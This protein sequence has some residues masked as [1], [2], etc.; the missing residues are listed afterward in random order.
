MPV[1]SP[2]VPIVL[3]CLLVAGAALA[4][5]ER[6]S[7]GLRPLLA[8][9]AWLLPSVA[10]LVAMAIWLGT[11]L[12]EDEDDWLPVI[13]LCAAAVVQGA[14]AL[15]RRPVLDA[16]DAA[17][18]RNGRA[19]LVKGEAVRAVIAVAVILGS[20]ALGWIAL[21]LPW[22]QQ[23]LSIDPLYS[24]LELSLILGFLVL[25][26]FVFQRRGVGV[27]VGVGA[28]WFVGIA[29]F[30]VTT[31]KSASIMPG[32][33]LA[34]ETAAAVGGGYVYA[35]DGP[36][37]I[38]IAC[39]LAAIGACSFVAPSRPRGGE[40]LF[41]NVVG[42]VV[43]ALV[44]ASL[45]WPGVT[46]D[47]EE[48]LDMEVDYWASVSYFRAHG[49]IPSFVK[50]VQD[51]PIDR[52]E[53]Y[54]DE[55]AAELEARYAAEYDAGAGS[56]A[57]RLAAEEQ[58]EQTRP[59]VICIM[60][61]SFSDLSF[62]NGLGVGYEGPAFYHNW[63]GTTLRGDLAVSVQGGSTCNSEFEFFTGAS[64]A[65][66]GSGK[67]PYTIYDLSEAPSVV[68]QFSELGYRTTAIHPER[69]TNWN[70]A[71]AYQDLGFDEFI[72]IED[73]EGA[74]RYHSG[75]TDGAT[76][77][78]ILEVLESSDGP[79]FIFG[80]TMQN[81]GGYQQRNI[82]E[83]DL[84]GYAP[85]GFIPD[86]ITELNEYLACIDATDRDLER[87]VS[88]LAELDRPVV[89]VF[90][91]DHQPGTTRAIANVLFPD[92]DDLTH[93][94][95][96]HQ[97]TYAVWANYPIATGEAEAAGDA[98]AAGDATVAAE[99]AVD[100][101]TVA[102]DEAT[103]VDGVA[104]EGAAEPM[105]QGVWDN[106]SPAYLAAMTLDAIGAPL[107]DFQKAQLA[108]RAEIP[109][110]SLVGTRLADGTWLENDSRRMADAY[111]DLSQITYLEFA[112]KVE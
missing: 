94:V 22:N 58:F 39:A 46:M 92:D 14:C 8:D 41:G 42:N 78:K 32:D 51:L 26:Y 81:H 98:A 93:A 28:L 38:G 21:E 30:F 99:G 25:L 9:L 65:Y 29:Q 3:L 69:A 10:A 27:A 34:L 63:Q 91:G 4:V 75:V 66:V 77:D 72:D 49:F 82:P 37:L 17:Q 64:L 61:E 54:S 111:D 89:L 53:D 43:A 57:R 86:A 48:E 62:M 31:F 102:V 108:A 104:S 45:L 33:L 5:R 103:A 112:T 40:A 110:V 71:A 105:N 101:T 19:S 18:G 13:A 96:V 70:R 1:P 83:S 7:R 20:C 106:T 68:R 90:F 79:Q 67:Y 50:V 6:A 74:P 73:F 87:F 23:L 56:S 11:G 107:T 76:F 24:S 12:Y 16:L 95:R 109:A 55:A 44:V 52:P 85:A 100:P 15:M 59:S 88:Q 84:R 36:V 60:D 97:T 35:V 80:L 2:V 47:Y